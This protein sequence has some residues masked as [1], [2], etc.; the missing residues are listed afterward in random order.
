MSHTLHISMGVSAAIHAACFGL[1]GSSPARFD[2]ARGE[3]GPLE[4]HIVAE[5]A[6]GSEAPRI[7]PVTGEEPTDEHPAQAASHE[8]DPYL[9][10]DGAFMEAQPMATANRPPPYPWL[11][12]SRGWEGVVVISARVEKDGTV[13][14]TQVV[15]SSS[16][17]VLDEA[18]RAAIGRWTFKAA[19]RGCVFVASNVTISVRF[20]LTSREGEAF[21]E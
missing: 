11:A 4:L 12:R 13:S 2:V 5:E 19:S 9:S 17:H 16:H 14:A 20:R 6:P 3:I 1:C 8:T 15:T 10:G 18:A 7:I 21:H